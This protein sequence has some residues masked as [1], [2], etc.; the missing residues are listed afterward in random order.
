MVLAF[1]ASSK[2]LI[3]ARGRERFVLTANPS[4]YLE[5]VR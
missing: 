5:R 2:A 1:L 3:V 4:G